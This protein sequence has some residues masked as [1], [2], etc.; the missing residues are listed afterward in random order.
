MTKGIPAV[1]ED[2]RPLP[3]WVRYLAAWMLAA[4][5]AFVIIT[6]LWQYFDRTSPFAYLAIGAFALA[7]PVMVRRLAVPRRTSFIY[8]LLAIGVAFGVLSILTG[9]GNGLTDE[10]FT[11]PRFAGFLLSGH[12]PYVTQLVFSYQQ[13]GETLSSR[14]YYLYLPL[15][16]FLQIPG[17]DY[18]WFTLGC[19][20]GMV[21]LARKNFDTAAMLAQ[22]YVLLIA[23]SGYNDVPVLL[24]L[25]L[26]FVG[27]G[28]RRQKWAEYLSLGCKQFANAFVFVYYLVR[29]RWF[30]AL[31]TIVVSA[32]FLVPFVLWD[33]TAVLCPSVFADRL[34]ACTPGASA[35]ILLNYPVWAVWIVAVFYVPARALVIGWTS[36]PT[37]AARFFHGRIRPERLARLPSLAV[38]AASAGSLGLVTFDLV[39]LA[40]GLAFPAAMAAGALAVASAVLWTMVWDG[41]WR[42][43]TRSIGGP[44]SGRRRLVLSQ[45]VTAGVALPLLWGWAAAGGAALP[46][47][48]LGISLGVV[49]N[50]ALLWWWDLGTGAAT[51]PGDRP[52]VPE[53]IDVPRM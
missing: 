41:P 32:A 2:R 21:L 3:S 33:G 52:R 31:L 44:R 30:D 49:A 48:A 19:W 46:G 20:V 35:G 51:L 28:G 5:P 17:I 40:L 15:L 53:H 12:D 45:L 4:L 34:S 7:F 23:A 39:T 42:T 6:L 8:L 43:S 22:P 26:G 16:M 38:V 47:M 50:G 24:L 37:A 27:F 18:K 36:R 14:S 25:T 11:T 10:P 29:R 13:Y 9:W 1:G